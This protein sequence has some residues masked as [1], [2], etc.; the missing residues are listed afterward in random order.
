MQHI[1]DSSAP[2]E[3]LPRPPAPTPI[4]AAK[5]ATLARVVP[6]EEPWL[7]EAGA[8]FRAGKLVA[9]P[10]GEFAKRKWVRVEL[11]FY[12]LALR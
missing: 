3:G 5:A 2:S 6:A 4:A 1:R 12:G 10:T 11:P 9:F 8:R 7:T